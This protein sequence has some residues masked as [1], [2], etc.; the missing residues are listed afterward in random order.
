MSEINFEMLMSEDLDLP[1]QYREAWTEF[2]AY[3]KLKYSYLFFEKIPS[4][5]IGIFLIGCRPIKDAS[6]T[7]T[8][9]MVKLHEE[10]SIYFK[11]ID[12]DDWSIVDG[13]MSFARYLTNL[14]RTP[15]NQVQFRLME[16]L[17][18]K[19]CFDG[20]LCEYEP[21]DITTKSIK[22]EITSTESDKLFS[23]ANENKVNEI[24]QE[25][26]ASIIPNLYPS[27]LTAY[28]GLRYRYFTFQGFLFEPQEIKDIGDNHLS[29]KGKFLRN[30][31]M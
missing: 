14:L 2:I 9:A 29:F 30:M 13:K 27:T 26:T 17:N 25:V 1:V 4:R 19:E 3:C 28:T 21:Y 16:A 18:N 8:L 24:S 22:F 12:D 10:T 7:T 20:F 5:N 31:R 6:V 11:T 23:L 15:S